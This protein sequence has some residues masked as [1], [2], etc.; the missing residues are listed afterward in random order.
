MKCAIIGCGY[1]GSTLADLWSSKGYLVTCTTTKKQN[2]KQ[3][4]Q[5]WVIAKGTDLNTI[6][7][8]VEENDLILITVTPPSLEDYRKTY[9]GTAETIKQAAKNVKKPKRLIFTS[10]TSVYGDHKGQWV[11][12][13]SLLLAEVI[14]IKYLIEAEKTFLSLKEWGWHIDILRLCEI[15]GPKRSLRKKIEDLQGKVLPGKGNNFAN[16]VHLEDVTAAIDYIQS[17]NLEGI[18]NLCDDEHPTQLE[19]FNKLA[20]LY[21]QDKPT[22]DPHLDLYIRMNKRISNHKIKAAGYELIHPTRDI[23]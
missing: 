20:E 22:W 21:Q 13:E 1:V 23:S 10:A 3:G 18:Y 4:P 17:H 14:E 15:Y 9:L 19:F 2:I 16:M 11:D 12:E 7:W 5:N 6:T 8:L